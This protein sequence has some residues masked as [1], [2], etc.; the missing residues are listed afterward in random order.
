MT[1]DIYDVFY[2]GGSLALFIYGMKVMSEGLQ[3]AG[4]EGFKRILSSMTRNRVFGVATGFL[5]TGLIQSSSATTVM[6]VSFVNAGLL[7]LTESAGVMM[8]ANVGTT[9]TAWFLSILGFKVDIASFTI[10]LLIISVPMLFIKRG[11]VRFWGE[12]ITGFSLLF[13]GLK[14]LKDGVPDI[15]SNP[16]LLLFVT[17]ITDLGYFSYILF[18][19]VGAILTVVVQSSSATMA[20]TLVMTANGW[21]DFEIAA[22]MILGENIG[23][24]V[25][26]EIA[27]LPANVH[28]KRSARIHSS[29][30]VIGVSWMLLLF[31]F[32][33]K[34]IA[35]L[36]GFDSV[37]ALNQSTEDI[38]YALSS[39]HT[40]F[41]VINLLLLIGFVPNLVRFVTRLIPSKSKSDEAFHLEYLGSSIITAEISTLE[42]KKEIS[43]M[44]NSL[45]GMLSGVN[46]LLYARDDENRKQ[47]LDRL[48]TDE[49]SAD[50]WEEE[51][52]NFLAKISSTEH[53]GKSSE[54]I[55]RMLAIVHDIETISD[56]FMEMGNTL[57]L[58]SKR[59]IW[60]APEQR[61]MISQYFDL[62][63]KA[64]RIM[65]VNIEK[66][67]IEEDDLEN[68]RV[69]E[70]KIN[71]F[72]KKVRKDYLLKIEEGEYN[73]KGGV[74]YTDLFNN[75]ERAGDYLFS[76]S[77]TLAA[78]SKLQDEHTKA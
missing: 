4:G 70:I 7:T 32:F 57:R 39:F 11:N 54:N 63:H 41:N 74:V 18:V 35:W 68:A 2:L 17:D 33:L 60:F 25:T 45:L 67:N 69:V 65:T 71:K 40:A 66:W 5:I 14:L 31:P 51:I 47:I 48:Q 29:F 36:N 9:V 26:A 22:A 59:K 28:A 10:P 8:G 73:I 61:E 6:T 53:T 13:Y 42:A 15:Q 75:C 34:G 44:S 72:R 52:A 56:I 38:P 78:E 3:K 55:Q 16:D 12:A 37:E 49:D 20:I 76:I 21:I 19:A 64:T 43:R 27:S 30:N 46:S 24:T 58:K 77:E 62:V 1:F 50:K 23:T